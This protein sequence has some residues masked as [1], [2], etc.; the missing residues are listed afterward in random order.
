MFVL[1]P[2]KEVGLFKSLLK[3]LNASFKPPF[4]LFAVLE[5]RGWEIPRVLQCCPGRDSNLIS[6]ITSLID[7]CLEEQLEVCFMYG[8]LS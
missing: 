4:F 7:V 8:N 6:L 1:V 3:L 5:R 2:L